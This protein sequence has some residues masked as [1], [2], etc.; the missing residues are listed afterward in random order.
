M[1]ILTKHSESRLKTRTGVNKKITKKLTAEALTIGLRHSDVTGQLK[2][3][4]DKIYLSHRTAN[5][6]RI[7]KQ[8]VFLFNNEILITVLNLPQKFYSTVNKINNKRNGKKYDNN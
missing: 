2:R 4:L 5:N 1:V 7:H 6:L 3:Y 8:K